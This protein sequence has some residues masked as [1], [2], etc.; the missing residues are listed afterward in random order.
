MSS[1][2][3]SRRRILVD[4]EPS[5]V[6][7]GE[8]HYFRLPRQEWAA[9]LD[10]LVEVG[11][12]CV[13]SY[14][15]WLWHELPDGTLDV[16]GRTRP[17]R[18]VGAFIDLAAERGLTFLA[19]PGP[20]VMAELKNEGLPYRLYREHPEIVPVGWDGQPAPTATVDYLAPAFLREV[21][22]WYDAILPVLAARSATR[23]GPVLGVQLDNEV[24]MLAWVSNSPDLTDHLVDDLRRWLRERPAGS[25]HER[26][27]QEALVGVLDGDPQRWRDTVRTPPEE[28][29][30][31]LRV[32]LGLFMRDR[33]ARYLDTL[34][35]QVR[36][37]GLDGLPLFVNIHGTEGGN[38]VPFA[39]GV[40]Q[41]Y[42]SYAGMPGL[43]AGSDH[44]LGEMGRDATTDIHFVNA[45]ME[46]VNGADQP[47]TSL[48]FEAGTGDYDAGLERLYDGS[49]V[50]LKVRLHLAQGNRLINY[51]LLAGG[52]NPRLDEPVG[53]GNDR[54]SFTGRRHGTAAPIGP[55]GQR[56]VTFSAT[57]EVTRA[58]RL[59]ARWLADHDEERDDVA[60]AFWPDAFLTEYTH[61]GSAAV[62]EIVRDLEVHRGPG[63]RKALWRSWL[64]DGW[65]FGAVDVSDPT[66]EAPRVL[67]L[68]CG[69]VLDGDV[70]T[71]LVEHVHGG[72]SL[73]LLGPV[74][75]RDTRGRSCTVLG[76]ALGVRGGRREVADPRRH[77]PSVRGTGPLADWT[78][79][80]VGW[81][82]EL[83]GP[84]GAV[85]LVESLDG[86]VC[87]L[88]VRHGAGRTV[89]LAA[90][91]PGS[92]Q[93][94]TP[95]TEWLGAQRGTALSTDVP[96]VVATT[97]ATPDGQRMLH[98]LNPTAYP[99]TVRLTP[100][101]PT[102][103]LDAPLDM[104]A[105]TGV[106]LA[107]GLDLP[108]G[109]RLESANAE[110]T[111]LTEDALEVGAGLGATT[112]LWLSGEA[113]TV[114][115]ADDAVQVS[116]DDGRWHVVAPDRRPVRL[117]AGPV[118]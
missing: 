48:E 92:P 2:Q 82:Q 61:P 36:A 31:D 116:R 117:T 79:M 83:T 68:A 74:P 57:R 66:S 88:G 94:F 51:Y 24:G 21:E 58:A 13:A 84:E 63:P 45:V 69:E 104:P 102:G 115:C 90:E 73:L 50:D 76:D 91:V 40:S 15:P 59:H 25:T 118:T 52:L 39:I 64:F 65:R 108:C 86:T 70:Q 106:I 3:I 44:Y 23:G 107:L 16:T 75:T 26:G 53:D 43:V 30:A 8:V 22:R 109:L 35:L 5:L 81:W 55:E 60:V 19:R 41:L 89:V 99:A 46:A 112:E 77:H 7:A 10:L 18:D 114:R 33:F 56:G 72:G 97:S 93:L 17:E 95:V 1:V 85:P 103:L 110:L 67:G 78:E 14:I 37:S 47:L 28:L 49:T 111:D 9:R 62:R 101:D 100:G 32:D 11:C 96:G 113:G 12:T 54:I 4:G 71:R 87:G 20:F 42:R 6:M 105:R 27:A 80:R 38:G 34:A 29:A 98:L